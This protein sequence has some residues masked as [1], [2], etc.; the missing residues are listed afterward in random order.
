MREDCYGISKHWKLLRLK[1]TVIR[2]P[3]QTQNQVVI[4]EP[5][6]I[7]QAER[8]EEK[9]QHSEQLTSGEYLRML[10]TSCNNALTPSLMKFETVN[11]RAHTGG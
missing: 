4:R 6:Q 1:Q 11:L 2:K 5:Q 10:L 8:M 3:K 9:N 7:P